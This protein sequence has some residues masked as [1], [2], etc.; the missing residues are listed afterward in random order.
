MVGDSE[1]IGRS[2]LSAEFVK[3]ESLS[4]TSISGGEDGLEEDERVNGK[5]S[6]LL[7]PL[8]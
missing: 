8:S 1:R 7:P 4:P 5:M 6:L 3:V 2:C